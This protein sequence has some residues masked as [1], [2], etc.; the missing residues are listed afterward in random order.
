MVVAAAADHTWVRQHFVLYQLFAL[1][2]GFQYREPFFSGT[3]TT[4]LR[5]CILSSL[6]R[7]HCQCD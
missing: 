1:L 7:Y 6:P 4:R 2:D 3:G 5:Q